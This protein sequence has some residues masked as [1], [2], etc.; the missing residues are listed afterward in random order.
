MIHSQQDSLDGESAH[1]KAFTYKQVDT[2]RI[3]AQRFML[4]M[5]FK[6]KTPAF[7]WLNTG[8]ALEHMTTL[9]G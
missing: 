1:C 2:N 4:E 9:M 3:N 5:G 7:E 6:P 8:H